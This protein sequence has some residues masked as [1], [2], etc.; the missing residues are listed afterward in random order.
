MSANLNKHIDKSLARG[1]AKQLI[2]DVAAIYHKQK[3]PPVM[4]TI[5]TLKSRKK[6]VAVVA[7][8]YGALLMD[9]LAF[10]EY[11]SAAFLTLEVGKLPNGDELLVGRISE[12]HLGNRNPSRIHA[13]MN[14][15]IEME[16]VGC[17]CGLSLHSI[18]RF[19]QRNKVRTVSD[20][21]AT[22]RLGAQWSCVAHH[23][24]HDA[25]FMIPV[26]DGLIC[27]GMDLEA[28]DPGLR[29]SG[30]KGVNIRTFIGRED[31]RPRTEQRWNRMVDA[32]ALE[33]VPRALKRSDA[34]TSK[35]LEIFAVMAE[36]GRLWDENKAAVT[37]N[38]N[39]RSK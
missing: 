26:S 31:M 39:D 32:G 35:H 33:V 19:V 21:I 9:A 6:V 10:D 11:R 16:H 14:D 13:H 37:L 22:I 28:R 29:M 3:K 12:M 27:C 7:K 20:L 30:V 38:A 2:R 1:I 18:E 5:K 8:N 4:K 17:L 23:E 34:V 25:S 24:R 36:E 15:T